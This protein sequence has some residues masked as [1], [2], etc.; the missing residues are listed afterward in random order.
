MSLRNTV[1][2]SSPRYR[3]EIWVHRFHLGLNPNLTYAPL[4]NA[5]RRLFV[6]LR[7]VVCFNADV[8]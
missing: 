1:Y 8:L 2:D 5:C 7:I 6:S 3:L 4:A